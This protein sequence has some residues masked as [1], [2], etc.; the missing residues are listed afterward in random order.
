MSTSN[1]RGVGVSVTRLKA[2]GSQGPETLSNISLNGTQPTYTS[3]HDNTTY[4]YTATI[5][6]D[7]ALTSCLQPAV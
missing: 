3:D 5:E 4:V 1:S 2:T 7:G 6:A